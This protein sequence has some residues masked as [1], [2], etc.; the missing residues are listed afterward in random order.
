MWKRFD[1]IANAILGLA[2]IYIGI[3]FIAHGYWIL[4]PVALILG[5]YCSKRFW[6]S[7][8]GIED[9]KL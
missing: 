2:F 7:I 4:S 9:N 5:L 6:K 3:D 1:T 8:L